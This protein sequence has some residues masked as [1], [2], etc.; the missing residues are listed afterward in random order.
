[1]TKETHAVFQERMRYSLPAVWKIAQFVC[2]HKNKTVMLRPTKIAATYQ[3]RKKF[4][5]RGDITIVGESQEWTYE[6][7]RLQPQNDAANFTDLASWPEHYHG[8]M[9]DSCYSFDNK[10]KKPSVYFTVNAPMTHFGAVVVQTTEEFWT[11]KGKLDK[12]MG[13]DKR[14]YYCPQHLVIFGEILQ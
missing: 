13:I 1:M 4:K 9:V 6:V 11:T 10:D 2:E 14:Y 5:D 7:K 3:E 12:E 8:Y